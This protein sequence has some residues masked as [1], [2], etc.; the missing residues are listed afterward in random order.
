M[1]FEFPK[2]Q[3]IPGI[4][5]ASLRVG[6][7][8]RVGYRFATEGVRPFFYPLLGP[9]RHAADADRSPEPGRPRAP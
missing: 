3:A 5:G 7:R 2:V 6:G 1:A 9:A 8:E 4:D